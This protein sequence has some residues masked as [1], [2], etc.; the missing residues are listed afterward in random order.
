MENKDLKLISEFNSALCEYQKEQGS[1]NRDSSGVH[2]SKY[3][4]WPTLR[5]ATRTLL[6]KHGFT[7]V[8]HP[9][10]T[11]SE[12]TLVMLLRHING[13]IE[14]FETPIFL[15]SNVK[16]QE[17]GGAI[18]YMK[19]YIYNSVLGIADPT[20]EDLDDQLYKEEQNESYDKPQCPK[21]TKPMKLRS[22]KTTGKH[23]WG[24]SAYPNC[25]GFLPKDG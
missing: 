8:I 22:S 15:P 10:G 11:H 18:T 17:H 2:G 7:V 24:C 20:E 6:T 21:C 4:S 5:E 1:I 23:F 19:R 16:P 3:A 13:H 14:R 25:N 9:G 12:P